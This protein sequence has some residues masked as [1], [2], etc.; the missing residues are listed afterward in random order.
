MLSFPPYHVFSLDIYICIFYNE[1]LNT[2]TKESA[3]EEL[4]PK[5]RGR[6]ENLLAREVLANFL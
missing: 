3:K 6:G 5:G 1:T 2:H 4:R